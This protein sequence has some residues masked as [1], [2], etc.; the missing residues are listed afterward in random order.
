[1]WTWEIVFRHRQRGAILKGFQFDAQ[2]QADLVELLG[3]VEVAFKVAP[4]QG[5]QQTAV[6]QVVVEGLGV[7]RQAHV[8]QPGLGHPVV[9]HAGSLGQPAGKVYETRVRM[10][11]GIAMTT[12]SQACTVPAL[13]W[14]MGVILAS[15]TCWRRSSWSS[16]PSE[17]L[18]QWREGLERQSES[19]WWLEL[20][21][22]SWGS[23]EKVR[24][25]CLNLISKLRGCRSLLLSNAGS[26]LRTLKLRFS[27]L[28][29]TG[30][31]KRKQ[32][33]AE[34]EDTGNGNREI[35]ERRQQKWC[36]VGDEDQER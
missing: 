5:V 6:D 23:W 27:G 16:D 22:R 32:R 11:I 13:H 15:S 26:T 19:N 20:C 17:R 29:G 35:P 3:D 30:G 28:L 9:V 36:R 2:Q 34:D 1:M 33:G 24:L 21:I 18:R 7:L 25:A 4:C 14:D 8:T 31:Q 10:Y 12:S